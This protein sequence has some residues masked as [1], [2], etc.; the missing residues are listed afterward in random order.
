VSLSYALTNS[1][2]VVYA[3]VG[4]ALGADVMQEYMERFGFYA[5]P[6]MDYPVS[7]MVRSGELFYPHSCRNNKLFL[8]LPVT[9]PCVDLGRTAIGQ[10]NLAVTPLQMAMVVSAIADK[11]T[12]MQPRLTS[13]VVNQEGQVVQT[14]SPQE[15]DQVM[16]PKTAAEMSV[17]MRNVVEEGTGQAANLEGQTIAGKTGT[18][19]IFGT[20]DGQPLD[21]AWFVGFAPVADPKIAVA[22]EL[23]SIPNGYGGQYAA[24]IAAKVIQTLLAEGQ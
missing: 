3:Q 13:K 24:P 8:L 2:N 23:T 12:L 5:F 20:R 4:E 16:K 19:S 18:A 7:Q 11:G 17:M 21:D 9:D 15:D 22:V 10:S 1:I 6:P 14:I